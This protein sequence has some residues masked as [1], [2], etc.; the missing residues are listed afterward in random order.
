L[1][2]QGDYKKIFDLAIND[3]LRGIKTDLSEF[4]VE[5]QQ[6]FC[7]QTLVDSGLSEKTVKKLQDSGHIYEKAGAL[8]FKTTDFGD[9]LDRV[10]VRDNGM[11]TYFASD[12]A[13]HLEKFERGYDK[14]INIWGADHHGY[15]TRVKASIQAL[16]HNP[17]KLE[18][19]L[20]QFANLFR[21]GEKVAMST[22]SGSFITQIIR[23]NMWL[24]IQR[25]I[26]KRVCV[27]T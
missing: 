9:D 5:Y 12:I 2:L 18:I 4:G 10:V 16:D 3:I 25:C 22:R 15:I 13:Y 6:W 7:E 19:L 27:T 11:H 21:N 23:Q 26:L 1:Q 8:W 17:D 14:I 24:I 20:V